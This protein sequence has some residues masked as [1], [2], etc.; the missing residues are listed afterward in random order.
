MRQELLKKQTIVD[1]ILWQM[2]K[3]FSLTVFNVKT[4]LSVDKCEPSPVS[5]WRVSGNIF[6]QSYNQ[7]VVASNRKDNKGYMNYLVKQF[8]DYW[9]NTSI[10]KNVACFFYFRG[11][12][13]VAVIHSL[14]II[15]SYV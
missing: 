9:W 1:F 14:D 4:Y 3:L 7:S 11:F 10:L 15:F 2:F 12:T 13:Y 5:I 6:S 8:M